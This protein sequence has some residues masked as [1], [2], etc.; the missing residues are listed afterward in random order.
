MNPDPNHYRE[1]I[2]NIEAPKLKAR[3]LRLTKGFE[4]N[5]DV[6]LHDSNLTTTGVVTCN[7]VSV[8]R[9]AYVGRNLNVD[10]NTTIQGTLTPKKLTMDRNLLITE[11]GDITTLGTVSSGAVSTLSV[12]SDLLQVTGPSTLNGQ[13][14]VTGTP[15][16]FNSDL[17]IF[18][19]STLANYGWY[20]T[21]TRLYCRPPKY[22]GIGRAYFETVCS[23]TAPPNGEVILNTVVEGYS[24]KFPISVRIQNSEVTR[25]ADAL[26]TVKTPWKV[27][28]SG[29]DVVAVSSTQ[30]TIDKLQLNRPVVGYSD[31]QKGA[32]TFAE[33]GFLTREICNNS[34]FP[35]NGTW[36]EMKRRTVTSC[37]VY[38]ITGQIR[39]MC[40]PLNTATVNKFGLRLTAAYGGAITL[41]E[42]TTNFGKQIS[43][44]TWFTLNITG[45]HRVSA[46][47][48][49]FIMEA[50]MT[51]TGLNT[52]VYNN[53][54]ITFTNMVVT[55]IA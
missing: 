10:G 13:V 30:A 48:D 50:S 54:D 49:T 55:R 7:D 1:Y 32:T 5:G 23:P 36:V 12:D 17:T 4:V 9:D 45:V 22:E 25:I 52:N 28:V 44:N 6:E 19:P 41:V 47:N 15:T 33:V 8:S 53:G 14:T 43:D 18:S 29:T 16:T 20:A 21:A 35:A 3:E 39:V 27:N 46:A 24:N 31:W 11:N 2:C 34:V 42:D 51:H 38:M 40:T 37:G 26:T